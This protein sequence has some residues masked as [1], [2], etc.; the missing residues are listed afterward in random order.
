MTGRPGC[1]RADIDVDLERPRLWRN[2][3]EDARFI[4]LQHRIT[5]LIMNE[6][7]PQ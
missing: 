1:I 4:E 2:L 3:D 5:A 7:R 6:G